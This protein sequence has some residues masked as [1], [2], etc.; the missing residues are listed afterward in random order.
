MLLAVNRAPRGHAKRGKLVGR[1]GLVERDCLVVALVQLALHTF[2]AKSADAR[3]RMGEALVDECAVEAQDLENLRGVVTLHR[4]DAHLRHDGRDARGDR[5]VVV[6]DSDVAVHVELAALA[7][8]ADALVRH[9]RVD[10][11]S[12]IAHQAGEIVR[13]HRVAGLHEQIGVGAQAHV[14]QVVVHRGERKKT[15]DGDFPLARAIGQHDQVRTAAH[16]RL[17]VLAQ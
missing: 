10:A 3:G 17:H 1:R 11:R 8:I 6:R 16:G 12:G 7:Q 5:L 13:A 9:V 2:H 15:R 14:D 4:G